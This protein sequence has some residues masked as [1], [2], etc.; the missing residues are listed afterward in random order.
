MADQ[1]TDFVVNGSDVLCGKSATKEI[2]SSMTKSEWFASLSQEQKNEVMEIAYFFVLDELEM[3]FQDHR[4]PVNK[5]QI[6]AE[7]QSILDE[8]RE[9]KDTSAEDILL[10]IGNI[11]DDGRDWIPEGGENWT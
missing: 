2:S 1:V 4:I 10:K 8:L 9:S 6:P 7:F 3:F 11:I 5:E